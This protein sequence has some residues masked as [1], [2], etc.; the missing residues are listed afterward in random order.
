MGG[1]VIRRSLCPAPVLAAALLLT[2]CADGTGTEDVQPDRAQE[3]PEVL[4]Y[5]DPRIS[6]PGGVRLDAAARL[7][8]DTISQTEAGATRRTLVIELLEHDP[9]SAQVIVTRAFAKEGYQ[10]AEPKAGTAGK[11]GIRY[12]GASVPSVWAVFYPNVPA[13]PAH[14][15]AKSMFSVSWQ[16]RAPHGKAK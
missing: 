9:D 11:I 2:A 13:T 3:R 12:A 16:V 6:L 14:P 15:E 4:R 8:A 10:A 1:N 5:S 7:R